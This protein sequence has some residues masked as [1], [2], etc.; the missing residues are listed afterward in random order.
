MPTVL[1]I[2]FVQLLIFLS[3]LGL[4]E[5]ALRIFAP[6]PVHGGIYLDGEGKGVRVA[7]DDMLLMPNLKV[8]HVGQEFS[9]PITTDGLGYR[10]AVDESTRPSYAFIGDSFTFGHG[11]AD[12]EIFP[13]IF[14]RHRHASCMNLG[15]SGT[16]TFDQVRILRHAVERFGL[17]PE[18]VV[19]IMLSACWIDSAGNDLGG[20][21]ADHAARTAARQAAV[22]ATAALPER[23]ADKSYVKMMQG[24]IGD[25]EIAK[26]AMLIVTSRLKSTLYACSDPDRI[27]AALAATKIAL[28]ELAQLAAEKHFKV[29][30]YAIHPYQELDGAYRRSEAAL[31]EVMPPRFV[32]VGTGAHFR[33]EHYFSYDGHF[34]AAG[35]A[36]MASLLERGREAK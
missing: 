25:F 1:K 23:K 27:A 19:L 4:I 36:N 32:Y 2:A 7:K 18:T 31:G 3:G 21:L 30:V 13:N 34:N 16:D 5:A 10:Q 12:D 15:R 20:N 6:L 9:V 29:E 33:K 28:D 22:A 17:E 14:C 11:V 24:W 26:R 8:A 35:H